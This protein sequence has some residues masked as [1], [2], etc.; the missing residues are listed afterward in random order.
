M[1]KK[2]F[3]RLI[4]EQELNVDFNKIDDKINYSKYEK[5]PEKSVVFRFKPSLALASLAALVVLSFGINSIYCSAYNSYVDKLIDKAIQENVLVKKANSNKEYSD[6]LKEGNM[7]FGASK[8][9]SWIES[10]IALG[11]L[12][13]EAPFDENISSVVQTPTSGNNVTSTNTQV[14]GIDEVDYSKCDGEYIYFD[15]F[16][17]ENEFTSYKFDIKNKKLI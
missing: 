6:A 17:N 2:D 8:K 14:N 12:K 16:I 7:L 1:N 11:D 9:Q 15:V 10:L 5:E 3:E 4:N 13:G